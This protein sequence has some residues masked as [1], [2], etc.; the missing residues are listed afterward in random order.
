VIARG[1]HAPR[2]E[3]D[4]RAVVGTELMREPDA[5]TGNLEI[6][7]YQR[8]FR[9][10]PACQLQRFGRAVRRS[11]NDV[12]RILQRRCTTVSN[13]RFVLDDQYHHH[14]TRSRPGPLLL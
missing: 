5:C 12:S 9:P 3:H 13:N 10:A 14:I 4:G 7:V 11:K 1:F 2:G 6:D 8:D